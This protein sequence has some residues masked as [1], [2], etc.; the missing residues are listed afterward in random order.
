M[1]AGRWR[2]E[3]VE[4]IRNHRRTNFGADTHEAP[5]FLAGDDTVGL[6]DA[7]NHSCRVER[8]D[9][10]QVDDLGADPLLRQFIGSLKRKA[11]HAGVSNQ[12]HVRAGALHSGLAN[13]ENVVVEV[14]HREA[15]SVKQFMLQED[16]RVRV[17]YGGLEQAFGISGIVRGDDLEAGHMA[18]P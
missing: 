8:A 16:D 2:V 11:D 17:A 14:R 3:I 12:R 1:N 5:A 13:R 6:L 10:T 7:L 9:G 4:S 18:V 15:R